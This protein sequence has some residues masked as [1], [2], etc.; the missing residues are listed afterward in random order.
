MLSN[1]ML[2]TSLAT[3]ILY[4]L[5]HRIQVNLLIASFGT[6]NLN[7][8]LSS[9]FETCQYLQNGLVIRIFSFVHDTFGKT[10]KGI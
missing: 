3:G 4:K 5:V 8:E 10:S 6:E 1:L 9:Q 7:G 2:L